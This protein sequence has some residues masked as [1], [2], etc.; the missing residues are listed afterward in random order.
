M[1]KPSNLS[2]R[3]YKLL[4]NKYKNLK[5]NTDEEERTFQAVLNNR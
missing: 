3:D 5:L 4:K 1:K 2:D